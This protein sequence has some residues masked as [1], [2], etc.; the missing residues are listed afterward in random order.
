MAGGLE[1]HFFV[2]AEDYSVA[3]SDAEDEGA[4]LGAGVAFSQLVGH[5][6]VLKECDWGEGWDG[7]PP[8]RE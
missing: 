7:F 2:A 8:A 6:V 4:A 1:G 3:A 5:F